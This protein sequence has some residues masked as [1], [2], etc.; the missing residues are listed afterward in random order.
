MTHPYF[1]AKAREC[2][3]QAGGDPDNAGALAT[4]AEEA[5]QIGDSR[6]GVIVAEDGELLAETRHYPA[7]M[8]TPG[9]TYITKA[10]AQ[11]YGLIVEEVGMAA[12]LSHITGRRTIHVT[13]SQVCTGA[14]RFVREGS[15]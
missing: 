11:R 9:V 1:T 10:D 12:A 2:F 13:M 15:K 4:W 7:T 14:G 5:K 8:S 6:R 3:S